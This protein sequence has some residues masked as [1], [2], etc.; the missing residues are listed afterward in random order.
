MNLHHSLITGPWDALSVTAN[1][2]KVLCDR[3]KRVRVT[4]FC[5]SKRQITRMGLTSRK[6]QQ[7][8]P[9]TW[10]DTLKS[11]RKGIANWQTKRQ[12]SP[13]L[14]DHHFKKEELGSV[15]ELSDVDSQILLQCLYVARIGTRDT[16]L[17]VKKLAR[18][19]IKLTQA[20]DRRLARLISYIQH[21]RNCSPCTHVGNAAQH[22]RLGPFQDSGFA[23]DLD[24]SKSTSGGVLCIFGSRTFVPISWI[25]KK[26]TSVSHGSTESEI[27]SL[28]V[29]LRMD[30]CRRRTI[31][32]L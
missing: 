5:W 29:G 15:G 28:D 21:T 10:R 13:C 24:D 1:Q 18:S 32:R 30:G 19:V 2:T 3:T 31:Y 17:S 4:N 14:D 20:C 12:S 26:Q 25:C 27:I 7:H 16:L 22:C 11:S 9:A 6:K 23:G 8:G